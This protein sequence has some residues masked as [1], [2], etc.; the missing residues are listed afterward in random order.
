VDTTPAPAVDT[1]PAATPAPRSD[2]N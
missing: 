2:R 1:T